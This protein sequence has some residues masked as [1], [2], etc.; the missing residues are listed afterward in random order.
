M[1]WKS[2]SNLRWPTSSHSALLRRV[3][4][5]GG[6]LAFRWSLGVLGHSHCLV[7]RSCDDMQARSTISKCQAFVCHDEDLRRLIQLL[8]SRVG[9]V[10]WTILCSDS[11]DRTGDDIE[12]LLGFDNAPNRRI[13]YLRLRAHDAED[14][15]S[16]AV[17]LG[18]RGNVIEASIEG[19]TGFVDPLH[20]VLE[21]QLSGLREWYTRVARADFVVLFLLFL[22][23]VGGGLFLL[24]GFGFIGV[25]N[26]SPEPPEIQRERV[27]AIFFTV[28]LGVIV[29]GW[30][31]NKIREKLFPLVTFAIGQGKRSYETLEKVRWGVIVALGVSLG[32]GLLLSFL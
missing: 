1:I 30:G 17:S 13:Q 25:S 9:P 8:E 4:G 19:S 2:D 10:S 6:L 21:S 18:G 32:A 29:A 11:I 7:L 28:V 23:F 16:A 15:C 24:F 3:V 5:P 12:E 26:E 31:L 22:A 27:V 14:R 20:L